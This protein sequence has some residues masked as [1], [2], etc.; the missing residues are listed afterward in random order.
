[1]TELTPKQERF[2]EEYL[3]DSNATAAAKRAGYSKKTAKETGYENLTKPHIA[4]AIESGR[5][6]MRERCAVTV[7]NLT[8]E[9]ELARVKAMA[10]DKGASAA[11]TA[12]MGKAKLHG[13]VVDRKELSGGV[14]LTHE[15]ALAEIEDDEPVPV[16]RPGIE[17]ARQS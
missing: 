17:A 6:V 13:L 10:D 11:V 3:I 2:V 1:M 15:E 9:L 14:H 8:E 4:A 5:A 12:I 16:T 7:E